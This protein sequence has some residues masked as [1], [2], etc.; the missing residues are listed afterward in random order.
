MG[1]RKSHSNYCNETDS[2]LS[3][4]FYT[5]RRIGQ[6]DEEKETSSGK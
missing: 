1:G 3:N 2:C 5:Q 6:E 4:T